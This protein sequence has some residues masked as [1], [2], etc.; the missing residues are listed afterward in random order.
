[1]TWPRRTSAVP[2]LRRAVPRSTAFVSGTAENAR[3]FAP[4]FFVLIKEN[5]KLKGKTIRRFA[6]ARRTS[7]ARTCAS[8]IKKA[9]IVEMNV[10]AR[11]V[12]IN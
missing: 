7:A 2:A 8:A 1:M 11:D 6:V 12:E 10:N 5:L 4:V 9:S 3:S